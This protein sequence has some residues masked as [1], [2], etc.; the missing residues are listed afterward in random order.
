MPMGFLESEG[1]EEKSAGLPEN[2]WGRKT[3]PTVCIVAAAG[4]SRAKSS[5]MPGNNLY[6]TNPS[7][8]PLWLSSGRI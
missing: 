6:S 2:Q 7:L 5:L 8:K 3:H 4:D 1:Q